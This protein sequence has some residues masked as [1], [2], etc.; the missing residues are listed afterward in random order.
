[1]SNTFDPV[2]YIN[3]PRWQHVSLGLCRIRRLLELIGNPQDSLKSVHVAGTN[4]KGSTC[5]FLDSILRSAGYK[6]GLFT[7]PYIETFEERVR[8]NGENIDWGSLR[9]LTLELRDASEQIFSETGESPTEFELMTALGF[10]YFANERCDICI[11]EVGLGGRLDSTNVITP[12]LS[13][14]TPI[15]LDH[16]AILGNTL[17]EIAR[18][19]AGIIKEGIPVVCAEQKSEA[20]SVISKAAGERL[21]M[22]ES[23]PTFEMNLKGSYQQ[24]NA[25]LAA[26]AAEV[27]GRLGWRI[28]SED[29]KSGIKSATW[30]ARF[31]V[32]GNVV[33]DGAHNVDGAR[34]LRETLDEYW[35]GK[36]KVAVFGVLED[37]DYIG[38]LE[39]VAGV[40][41]AFYIYEPNS[42]RALSLDKL[43]CVLE[44]HNSSV[45]RCDS[46]TDALNRAREDIKKTDQ[47]VV[48][49]G[50]LYSCGELRRSLV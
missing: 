27:L 28:S 29:I 47:R 42:P 33:L 46:A 41:D 25:A 16:V 24:E 9:A 48:C 8:V 14:I 5:T 22:K 36:H 32:F 11:I 17:E 18:E 2:A 12:E 13:V 50:S 3:E 31:E 26:T 10:Y 37:K 43:E 21:V 19:K 49:F 6:T 39:T 4:G 38:I 30:P 45:K 15:G 44:K 23:Y 35:Q 34:T 7:S 20:L 1:M 40:F